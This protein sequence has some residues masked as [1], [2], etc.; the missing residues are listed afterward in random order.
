MRNDLRNTRRC[1]YYTIRDAAWILGTEPSVICRAIRRSTV[2]AVWRR[3]RLLIP[4]SALARQL[5][6]PAG[7]EA[8]DLGSAAGDGIVNGVVEGSTL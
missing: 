6:W 1:V 3:G 8:C 7:A 5:A 2:C 4:A